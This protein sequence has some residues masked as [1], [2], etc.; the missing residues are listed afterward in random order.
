MKG[1]A[2]KTARAID[3]DAAGWGMAP[4]PKAMV[5]ECTKRGIDP[6]LTKITQ[7]YNH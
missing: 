1:Q 2:N 5:E 7:A 6:F 4:M 3:S